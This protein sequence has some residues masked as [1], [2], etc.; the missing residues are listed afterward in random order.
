MKATQSDSSQN[1]GDQG[2]SSSQRG[3]GGSQNGANQLSDEGSTASSAGKDAQAPAPSDPS[4]KSTKAQ[5]AVKTAA[6]AVSAADSAVKALTGAA[7]ATSDKALITALGKNATAAN[8]ARVRL[9]AIAGLLAIKGSAKVDSSTKRRRSVTR[10]PPSVSFSSPIR[11][12]KHL[13][14]EN[15]SI[16]AAG[17]KLDS[18]QSTLQAAAKSLTDLQAALDSAVTAGSNNKGGANTSQFQA[19]SDAQ[20]KAI[21][22]IQ[23]NYL[24]LENL[25]PD[26][27]ACATALS[28]LSVKS[29]GDINDP[30]GSDKISALQY[31]CRSFLGGPATLSASTTTEPGGRTEA[32]QPGQDGQGKSGGVYQKR[33]QD[34]AALTQQ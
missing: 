8:G 10:P 1:G 19:I 5:D 14:P 31:I 33:A 32:Y 18:A 23:W 30:T 25:Q 11:T 22:Q 24:K 13:C 28:S 29:S 17:S 26:V 16:Q 4:V 21:E 15:K 6:S 34:A 9:K 20:A 3:S 2:G 27:V 7:A 12:S